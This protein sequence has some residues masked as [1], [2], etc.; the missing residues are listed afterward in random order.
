MPAPYVRETQLGGLWCVIFKD[1][2]PGTGGIIDA[3]TTEASAR[4]YAKRNADRIQY[5]EK[6]TS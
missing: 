3:F 2:Y 1:A 5:L 4:E 6:M